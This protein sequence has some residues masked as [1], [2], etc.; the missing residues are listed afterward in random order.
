MTFKDHFSRAASAYASF[1]PTYPRA[2]FDFV[3][4][5]VARR[6]T[7]WDCAT[8]SGQA[9]RGLAEL[10]ERVIATDAS[11]PQIAAAAAHPRVEYRVARAE[12][13]GLESASVDAVTVAQALHWFDFDAFWAEVRRVLAPGGAIVVWSYGDPSLEDPALDRALQ[14]FNRGTVEEYWAPERML[15]LEGYRGLAF[16]FDEVETPALVLEHAWPLDALAG[17]ART[18]SASQAYAAA[19]GR[20]PVVMLEQELV[21]AGW[22]DPATPRIVRWPL[23]IRAGRKS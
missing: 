11:A 20:D 4:G 18:W 16:P 10:F 5:L 14:G 3:A 21:R 17:Y 12:S 22:G 23:S 2:L 15:V 13:S 6:R 19:H 8:G 7:A 1:R 9:A